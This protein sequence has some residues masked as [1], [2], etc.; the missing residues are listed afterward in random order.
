MNLYIA[1]SGSDDPRFNLGLE[2]YIF[3]CLPKASVLMYLWQNRD[4][5]V[6]GRTQNVWKE[7]NLSALETENVTLARRSTGGG[8]VTATVNNTEPL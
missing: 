1:G 5:V 3:N 2:E 8:A 7:C 4:T 6:I